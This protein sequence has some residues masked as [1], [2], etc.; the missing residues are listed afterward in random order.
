MYH[1]RAGSSRGP[2]GGRDFPTLLDELALAVSAIGSARSALLTIS[3]DRWRAGSMALLALAACL[4]VAGGT[5]DAAWHV[6]LR[7]ETFWSPPHLLLY[8]GTALALFAA[9]SG[10][11]GPWLRTGLSGIPTSAG[12]GL[13]SLAAEPGFAIA[14]AGALIVIGAAPLDDFWHRTFGRDV[15]VWSFPHLVALIGGCA[16]NVGAITAV[17]SD[18]ERRGPTVLRRAAIMLFLTAL[19]WVVMF[20]LNWY[21]LVLARVRDSVQYPV[22]AVLVSTP[23]LLLAAS[24]LG[25]GGATVVAAVYM[26][27]TAT[28]HWVLAGF[29][30]ALLPFPPVLLVPALGVDVAVLLVPRSTRAPGVAAGLAAAGLFY[31]AE[32]ASL[33]WYPHP[34]LPE[35]RSAAALSYFTAALARPWDL[36]HIVFGLPL[37]LAAG[38]PGGL[39][40]AWLATVVAYLA[41]P[42]GRPGPDA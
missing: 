21:T 22:L 33:A 13:R 24:A 12:R 23:V 35:P 25:K 4:G 19:L 27:Y 28:A 3:A 37:A 16:I 17:K 30:Y 15:D 7:R 2:W 9:V 39:L 34:E 1:V 32:A 6:T 18:M 26:G 11:V 41:R 40:G 20:G 31:L 8:V 36:E 38:V 10:L 14:A 5:W 42:A 29:G